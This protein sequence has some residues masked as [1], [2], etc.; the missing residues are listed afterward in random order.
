MI[1]QYLTLEPMLQNPAWVAGVSQR[2][3]Q[4]L[5]YGYADDNPV[6]G[7]DPTGLDALFL[8]GDPRFVRPLNRRAYEAWIRDTLGP[9][10]ESDPSRVF[11]L[12]AEN[13]FVD[14]ALSFQPSNLGRWDTVVWLG[15]GTREGLRTNGPA[16]LIDSSAF[17]RWFG[18]SSPKHLI[19]L[20]CEAGGASS[21]W[22]KETQQLLP[23]MGVSGFDEFIAMSPIITGKEAVGIRGGFSP[24]TLDYFP[25]WA[26]GWLR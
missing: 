3:R 1:S 7:T 4:A 14:R 24:A 23:Y 21:G 8:Y 5:S 12:S 10:L 19:V 26:S 15:H 6:A 18:G 2:G 25:S 17:A 13:G 20:G 16:G 11:V 22:R 9:V